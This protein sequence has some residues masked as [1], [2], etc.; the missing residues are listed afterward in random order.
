MTHKE[1]NETN[2]KNNDIKLAQIYETLSWEDKVKIDAVNEARKILENAQVPF[3]LFAEGKNLYGIDQYISYNWCPQIYDE[4]D[5]ISKVGSDFIK[6]HYQKFFY[7]VDYVLG[8]AAENNFNVEPTHENRLK[9]LSTYSF[10]EYQ[11]RMQLYPDEL[12][13]TQ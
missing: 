5:S 13:I 8:V 7:A 4:N 9:T 2:Q 12:K 11:S 1:Q 10:W 6:E 3:W